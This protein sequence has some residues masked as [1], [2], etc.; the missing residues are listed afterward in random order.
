MS[1][2]GLPFS[3]AT[4][5]DGPLGGAE[6]AFVGLAEALAARG[7]RV[8]VRNRCPAPL[9]H[10]GVRWRPLDAPLPAQVDLHVANRGH[11]LIRLV[12]QARRVAFWIHN[13]ARYL[14]KWRYLW[15]LAATRPAIVFAGPC[16]AATYP[17][18]AP[19]G[20]RVSIALGV[21]E[22]FRTVPARD[23]APRPR[24]VFASNPLR[25]LDWL[26]ALWSE[27]I[28][29]LVPSAELHVYA[30]APAGGK[31][32]PAA[33]VL[34]RAEAAP[35]VSVHAPVDKYRLAAAH[36]GSRVMLYRGDLGE[37]FC[38][39]LAEAQASGLPAVVGTQGCVADRVIDGE[40][41]HVAA[42]ER[43]FAEAAVALLA[44]DAL[45]LRQHRAAIA[46]QRGWGWA[47]AAQ[48]FER[49]LP[50]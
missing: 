33:A 25:S 3:G 30:A 12:P 32:A 27:R 41:G 28:R 44:D 6:T 47:E 24:A 31:G 40:T 18:W 14:L 9:D 39:A 26:V 23:R 45:W 20:P 38:L 17:R 10:D 16:H 34:R 37:T 36:G 7:H 42:G 35:G 48:A 22:A 5:R 11:R 21:D 46:R 43:D 1:D 29:P 4:W 2:D 19:G 50:A 8:E 15:R 49:L 13:P